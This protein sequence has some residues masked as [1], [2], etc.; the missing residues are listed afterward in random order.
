MHSVLN[1]IARVIQLCAP[2][3]SDAGRTREQESAEERCLCLEHVARNP[4]EDR[5]TW[6]WTS[7]DSEGLK[8]EARKS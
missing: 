4:T 8:T 6:A 3:P 1:M 7:L 2:S 5:A